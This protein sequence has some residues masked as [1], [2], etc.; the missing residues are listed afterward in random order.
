MCSILSPFLPFCQTPAVLSDPAIL[1]LPA[2]C[3]SVPYCHP[4]CNVSPLPA[5]LSP[6]AVSSASFPSY[7]HFLPY[8]QPLSV[9]LSSTGILSPS[10]NVVPPISWQN[11]SYLNSVLQQKVN[12]IVSANL[13]HQNN[14]IITYITQLNKRM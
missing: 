14:T 2:Y 9:I 4:C 3:C 10:R 12:R 7:C 1:S 6:F 8:R 5:I 13:Q 11:A